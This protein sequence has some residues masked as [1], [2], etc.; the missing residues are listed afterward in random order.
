MEQL[1]KKFFNRVNCIQRGRW[2]FNMSTRQEKIQA[3]EKEWAE[4][5]RWQA[6]SALIQLKRL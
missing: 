2:N 3:L 1:I 6:L 4:N 5:P